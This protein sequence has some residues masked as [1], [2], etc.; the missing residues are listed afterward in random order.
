MLKI[1]VHTHILPKEIPDWKEKFGYGGFI[2]L[3]HNGPGCARMMRDDGTGFRD[4]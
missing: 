3:N 4:I 2:T 1:D